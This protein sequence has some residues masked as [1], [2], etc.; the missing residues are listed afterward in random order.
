VSDN[1]TPV[2]DIVHCVICG[3]T[4]D[5]KSGL[6]PEHQYDAPCG[7]RWGETFAHTTQHVCVEI[8]PHVWHRCS[9]GGLDKHIESEA[10]RG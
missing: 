7:F 6:C 1:E 9:C 3:G 5:A 2:D 4:Q 10:D 8:E